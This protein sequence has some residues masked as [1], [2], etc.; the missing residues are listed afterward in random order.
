MLVS[1]VGS[2]EGILGAGIEIG[3]YF[4]SFFERWGVSP[5]GWLLGFTISLY[6]WVPGV[7]QVSCH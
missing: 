1:E 4:S 2:I 7:R 6:A 3:S 5:G